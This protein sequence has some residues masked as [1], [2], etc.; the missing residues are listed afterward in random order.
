MRIHSLSAA[1]ASCFSDNSKRRRYYAAYTIVFLLIVLF[2][3]SGF[4]VS[5]R[6]LIWKRDGFTQHFRALVY[7]SEYLRNILNRLVTGQMPVIPEWDFAIGEG[8][9]ILNTFHY[10][11]I[12]DPFAL[13]SVFVPTRLMPFFYSGA[14]ILRLYLAGVAFSELG[15]GTGLKNRYGILAGA[16]SYSFSA[17]GLVCAARHPYFLN[18]MVFFPLLILGMERVFQNKTQYLFVLVTAVSAASNFYFFY[19]MVVLAVVYALIRTGLQCKGNVR[20]GIMTLLR[21]LVSALN[22]VCIAGILFVPV[23]M[24]FIRDSRL[25]VNRQTGLFYPLYYY[26]KLPSIIVTHDQEYWLYLGLTAPVVLAVVLLFSDKTRNAFLKMLFI[27]C[28]AIILFPAGGAFLNGMSYVANR[29]SW[30]LILLCA[31][32]LSSEWTRLLSASGKQKRILILAACVFAAVCMLCEESR[33]I[34]AFCAVCLFLPALAV[35]GKEEQ[36]KPASVSVRS[37]I[38]TGIIILG[39]INTAFWQFS[40]RGEDYAK[41]CM[42]YAGIWDTWE[43]N[44]AFSVK[45]ISDGPYTRYSGRTITK[46]AN[47]SAGISSTHFGWS[48]GNPYVNRYRASLE[49]REQSLIAY[50]GY[51]DRTTPLA[52]SA[53]QYFTTDEKDAGIGLPYGYAVQD[54]IH[55][56]GG[57]YLVYRNKHAL[58]AGY[59]YDSCITEGEWQTLDAVL[60]QQI[61]L[62]TVVVPEEYG[63][64]LSGTV[65]YAEDFGVSYRTFFDEN[66]MTLSD[67]GVV[68]NGS[69]SYMELVFDE[70]VEN[71]ETYIR[72]EGLEFTAMPENIKQNAGITAM[73]SAGVMKTISYLQA[74]D[75]NY[76]GRQDFIANLG[77]TEEPVTGIT[78]SF[79]L[80]G[81]YTFKSIKVYRVGMEDYAE[82]I[83]NLRKYSLTNIKTDTN[84]LMGDITTDATRVLCVAVS[85]ADGW[86]GRID[87]RY[88][89]VFCVNGHYIGMVIPP[90]T[91]AITLEYHAPYKKA[92]GLLSAAGILF[93]TGMRFINRR[94]KEKDQA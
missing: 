38:M 47:V 81:V 79:P 19:M 15:F 92:G 68:T 66:K 86:T 39:V 49:M 8:A 13:F 67:T 44:E 72:F 3:Y 83:E 16:I 1:I 32:I 55:H 53:T 48:L 94:K 6:S 59:S 93:L 7:Y 18:P 40:A 36:A 11:V 28:S 73:S 9:D 45:E 31:Y 78:L 84:T 33:G 26:S 88:T 42:Q 21:L 65:G 34:P 89:D 70:A 69:N 60:R 23:F 71:A 29:W 46:N 75:R 63:D 64:V 52:L 77:Y 14:C 5:G 91:H 74:G 41:Q 58:P 54:I 35:T 10:Y 56:D 57:Y 25:S 61:L 62:H 80:R 90:G 51:D 22:G 12:G 85:Y 87:N 50:D 30:A 27:I 82:S 2:C 37:L 4:L 43:E 17:F 76:T 20:Q 24:M